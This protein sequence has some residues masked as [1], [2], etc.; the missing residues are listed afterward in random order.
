[1][2]S[3]MPSLSR[4]AATGQPFFFGSE[5]LGPIWFGHASSLSGM[6]SLSRSGG[7]PLMR[8]TGSRTPG[9]SGH[10]SSLSGRP[11]PSRSPA[12][13][14]PCFFGSRSRAP[15]ASGHASSLSGT[16]SPSRSATATGVASGVYA[17]ESTERKSGVPTPDVSPAATPKP[18]TK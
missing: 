1:S 14:H 7:Q 3:A 6:A 12:G 9:T 5:L 15:A 17:I 2:L 13:G 11:S 10:A 4:S 18:A 16:P 8:G